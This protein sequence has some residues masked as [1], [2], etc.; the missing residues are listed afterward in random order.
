MMQSPSFLLGLI[1]STLYGAIFHLIVG[2][3]PLRF[4]FFILMGW[5]GFWGA[6]WLADALQWSIVD[7]GELHLD[8]ATFG[9]ICAMVFGF[10]LIGK[11]NS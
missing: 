3:N 8:A 11:E 2:G 6:Q 10:W 4:L 5:L 1:L 9:S 7:I